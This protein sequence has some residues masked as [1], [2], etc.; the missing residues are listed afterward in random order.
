MATRS[1][2]GAQGLTLPEVK[3]ANVR[4]QFL[5]IKTKQNFTTVW[6]SFAVDFY[7]CFPQKDYV[8]QSPKLQEYNCNDGYKD[9]AMKNHDKDDMSSDKPKVLNLGAGAV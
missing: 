2:F 5:K 1:N 4:K 7:T 9:L 3:E 6:F 8:W